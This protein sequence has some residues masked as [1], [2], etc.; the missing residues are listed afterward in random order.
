MHG[1]IWLKTEF[2]R[3]YKNKRKIGHKTLTHA[4]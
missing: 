4:C 1:K 3:V 2:K